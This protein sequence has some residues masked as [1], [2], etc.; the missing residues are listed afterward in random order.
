MGAN[1][2]NS[3]TKQTGKPIIKWMLDGS[4]LTKNV[5]VKQLPYVLYLTLL[6][7]IY[8]GNS[9]HSQKVDREIVKLRLEIKNTRSEAITLQAELM[10]VRRQTEI[11]R[12]IREYDINL[13]ESDTP[14]MKIVLKK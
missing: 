5:V 1:G 12:L 10:Y 2:I 7:I 6:A 14:P 3:K 8:I 9:Y 13:I 11:A 4:L